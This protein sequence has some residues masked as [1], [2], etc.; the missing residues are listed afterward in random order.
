M[1]KST[2][3]SAAN[4]ATVKGA[5]AALYYKEHAIIAKLSKA[6]AARAKVAAHIEA[7]LTDEFLSA[8]AAYQA[9]L[10]ALRL[11]NNRCD[12]RHTL[13]AAMNVS[14]GIAVQ[15]KK[16]LDAFRAYRGSVFAG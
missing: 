4:L 15:R 14:R 7:Q 6:Y 16:S 9:N 11:A 5:R 3:F 12:S 10:S 2:L 13:F 8:Y 1:S